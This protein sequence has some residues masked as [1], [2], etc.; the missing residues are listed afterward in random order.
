MLDVYVLSGQSVAA[1][2]TPPRTKQTKAFI[3]NAGVFLA[4]LTI[5]AKL[6]KKH[7]KE[8]NTINRTKNLS[9]LY[10]HIF[11]VNIKGR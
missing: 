5:S 7:T 11:M 2:T 9:D 3:S 10:P 4:R 8:P 1:L 6:S